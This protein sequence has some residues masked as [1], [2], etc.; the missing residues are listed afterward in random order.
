MTD[1]EK[2]LLSLVDI[3]GDMCDGTDPVGWLNVSVDGDV[4][5]VQ[6]EIDEP[7]EVI[8]ESWKLIRVE[9]G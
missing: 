5:H 3:D 6:Y 1:D 2:F 9:N 4:L 8:G 7:R